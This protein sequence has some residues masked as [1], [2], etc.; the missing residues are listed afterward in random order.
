MC[1]CDLTVPRRDLFVAFSYQLFVSFTN[2][3]SSKTKR[4]MHRIRKM[5]FLNI[6]VLVDIML[7]LK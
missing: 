2:S 1:I 3:G 6:Y 7:V 5:T 4:Y